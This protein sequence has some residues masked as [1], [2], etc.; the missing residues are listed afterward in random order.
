MDARVTAGV[1]AGLLALAG[2]G[3]GEDGKPLHVGGSGGAPALV[4]QDDAALLFRSDREVERS[5][6]LLHQ[7]GVRAVRIT[8][9]WSQLAPAARSLTKPKFDATDPADYRAE[10]WAPI[11]RAVRLA[12][13]RHM[14]AIVDIAFWAP[15][16]AT[17]G[18]TGARPRRGVNPA[19]FAAFARAVARRYADEV[20]T[21]TLWNEPN[22]P[23][24]L[25]PQRAGGRV[26]SAALYRQMVTAA[27]PLVKKEAPE[28]VVLVG[29]L[30]AHGRR[31]GVPP[32]EFL[33]DLACVDRSLRPIAGGPC[34]GFKPIPGDGF[35]HHPYSTRTRPDRV[36]RSGSP[37]DVPLARVGRLAA[38]LDRL[39]AVGRISPKLRQI[40]ITEYG[41]ETNPPDRGAPYSPARAAR[42]M[43]YA[44]ALAAREPRVRTFAQ[45][46]VRDLA[47]TGGGSQR[48]GELP[49]WQSGL[50]F[51]D[52]RPKPLTFVLPAPLHAERVDSQFVRLWGRVRPGSGRRRVRIEASRRGGP[53]R[54]LFDGRTDGHGV[55]EA[56]QP[57]RPGTLF[58][59]ARREGDRWVYGPPVDAL[60]V[61]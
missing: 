8:A 27:Y 19:E 42:M 17:A 35:A 11:D 9:G 61:R 40:W 24:F 46:L 16:W 43:S 45:F 50:L 38:L 21:F 33:R 41:Y 59:I 22:H 52:G 23:G 36:E 15:V 3:G 26:A 31:N 44:E 37:D 14:A 4:V 5:M 53:W 51:A 34:V 10:A 2:C 54:A 49:D 32:L 6:D 48:V 56:E 1:A 58:R 30:A 25:Q 55:V 47:G 20:G 29:G 57:A 39:A 18:D 7:T 13:D 12:R 60:A 28:S